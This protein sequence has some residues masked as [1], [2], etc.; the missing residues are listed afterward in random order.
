MESYEQ[1]RK[2][3]YVV[4]G[5]AFEQTSRKFSCQENV[6]LRIWSLKWWGQAVYDKGHEPHEGLGCQLLMGCQLC[7]SGMAQPWV[8]KLNWASAESEA[9]RKV[10]PVLFSFILY[11]AHHV[12]SWDCYFANSIV[13]L[14]FGKSPF[15]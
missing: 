7:S 6:A 15:I 13:L 2:K 11:F 10:L 8:V 1:M 5:E 4:Q 3:K 14:L 12:D 9:G